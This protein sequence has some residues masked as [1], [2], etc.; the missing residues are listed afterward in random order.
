MKRL[1][2]QSESNNFC[3]ELR[4]NTRSSLF[5]QSYFSNFVLHMINKMTET[6]LGTRV[7]FHSN[8]YRIVAF[9]V[10]NYCNHFMDESY[11]NRLKTLYIRLSM[12]HIKL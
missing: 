11:K 8:P 7:L 3:L 2:C 10:Y 9:Q 12:Q 6:G 4:N 5:S 1:C